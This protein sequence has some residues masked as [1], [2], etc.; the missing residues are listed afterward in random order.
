MTLAIECSVTKESALWRSESPV[1]MMVVCTPARPSMTLEK[2]RLTANWKSKS[3][4]KNC[5]CLFSYKADLPFMSSCSVECHYTW[6]T[7]TWTRR[8]LLSKRS[9]FTVQWDTFTPH[10]S[11]AVVLHLNVPA[12]RCQRRTRFTFRLSASTRLLDLSCV[13]TGCSTKLFLVS[14]CYKILIWF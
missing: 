4:L 9:R 3:K 12:S 13:C 14:P 6:L 5:E 10:S 11:R 7:S 8:R 1:H 2:P